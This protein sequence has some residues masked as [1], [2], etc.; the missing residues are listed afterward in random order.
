MDKNYDMMPVQIETTYQKMLG[1]EVTLEIE[2]RKEGK[3]FVPLRD[4]QAFEEAKLATEAT[5]K[6]V[7]QLLVEYSER[8]CR[9]EQQVADDL[10]DEV[11]AAHKSSLEKYGL[12]YEEHGCARFAVTNTCTYVMLLVYMR[13]GLMLSVCY[14]EV[15]QPDCPWQYRLQRE[16]WSLKRHI[17]S[18]AV[19][20]KH[21][22]EYKLFA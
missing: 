5:G 2:I 4:E 15:L 20:I 11:R 12:L 6:A 17:R 10:I 21:K 1:C 13:N 22:I 16:W 14:E 3:V 19:A 9:G 18:K 8:L 7:R